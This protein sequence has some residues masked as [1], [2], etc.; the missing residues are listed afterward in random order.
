MRTLALLVLLCAAQVAASG[1]ALPV[2]VFRNLRAGK[3]QTVVVYGTSLTEHGP[4]VKMLQAWFEEK[5]PGK[6]TVINSGG[7]GQ[8]SGW[9][10]ANV[11]ARVCDKRP[12]LVFIEFGINDA[13]VR[14]KLTL[15]GCL[16]N[17]DGMVKAVREAN[18]QADIVLQ[19]MNVALDVGGKT[20]GTDRPQL[21]AFY[22]NYTG[23]AAKNRL[24]LVDNHPAWKKLATD[25]VKTFTSYAPD[26][27][28]P[29]TTG[30]AAI[31]WPN[32]ERLLTAAAAAAAKR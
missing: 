5:Y 10:L 16:A 8:H 21:D 27:L 9:G 22:A 17:L 11:K 20:A 3:A 23:Y 25:D 24:P 4:W 19:T 15:E 13:H 1:E 7:S 14:F 6:A 31:T 12:D 18:A 2:T 26:G 30:L 32:I 29:N 28:H